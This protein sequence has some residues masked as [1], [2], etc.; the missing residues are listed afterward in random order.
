ME[1][2]SIT[3]Q[4]LTDLQVPASQDPTCPGH[5]SQ[6]YLGL[7]VLRLLVTLAMTLSMAGDNP[8]NSNPKI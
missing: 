7:L 3:A 8:L 4:S 6:Y 5:K 2:R 1:A